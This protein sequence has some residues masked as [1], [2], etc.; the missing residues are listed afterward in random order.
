LQSEVR[1]YS[2]SCELGGRDFRFLQWDD[3]EDWMP[4]V[5]RGIQFQTTSVRSDILKNFEGTNESRLELGGSIRK[6][7]KLGA[8][9]N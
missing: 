9:H 6:G 4:S 3:W 2:S 1:I 5:K 8:D 7:E